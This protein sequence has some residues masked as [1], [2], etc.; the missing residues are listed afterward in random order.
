MAAT[1]WGIAVIVD[2]ARATQQTFTLRDIAEAYKKHRQGLASLLVEYKER[3][4]PLIPREELLRVKIIPARDEEQMTICVSDNRVY[5]RS[6]SKRSPVGKVFSEAQRKDPGITRTSE[7][8]QKLSPG[9]FQRRLDALPSL[10]VERLLIYD[11][12]AIHEKIPKR[13]SGGKSD[14]D[15]Y[16]ILKPGHGKGY[17]FPVTY[18]QWVFYGFQDSSV[19]GSRDHIPRVFDAARFDISPMREQVDGSECMVL[20]ARGYQRIWADPALGF[21]VRRREIFHEG[22]LILQVHCRDFDQVVPGVWLPREVERVVIGSAEIPGLPINLRGKPLLKI[23]E[24]VNRF[25]VNAA[26]HSKMLIL[27]P[28]PG[29][30]ISD[31]TLP[32]VD[33]SGRPI[34]DIGR[35]HQVT[36][37]Q[38]AD[39]ADLEPIKHEAQGVLGAQFL[40]RQ[41]KSRSGYVF[42]VVAFWLTIG[43]V[44][45]V[46]LRWGL[47]RLHANRSA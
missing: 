8:V 40:A 2:S 46:M 1:V 27:T 21:A 19:D 41:V 35:R 9:E 38:P 29:S 18:L 30:R 10:T 26:S 20:E 24:Q 22:T 5:Y 25:E 3:T 33:A 31:H 28:K 36:Y 39:A 7:A 16:A 34:D 6:V 42:R 11:G 43:V 14:V 23:R 37:I 13:A 4:D 15:S 45:V 44:G 12:A 47:R 32:P 17:Y